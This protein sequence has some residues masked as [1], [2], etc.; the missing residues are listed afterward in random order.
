MDR[1]K[2]DASR[3]EPGDGAVQ[4]GAEQ[5]PAELRAA[6][7]AD[8]PAAEVFDRLPASRRRAY[9]KWVAEA[10]RDGTRARRAARAAELLRRNGIQ[11]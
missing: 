7:K 2:S 8:P 11:R 6:L 10:K 9:A 3:V 4:S 5:V 1:Q